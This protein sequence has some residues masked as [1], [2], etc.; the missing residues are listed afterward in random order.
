MWCK[1]HGKR[2]ELIEFV[3]KLNPSNPNPYPY[4]YE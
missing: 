2:N 1:K 4:A 3:E